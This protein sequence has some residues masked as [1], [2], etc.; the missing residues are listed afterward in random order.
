MRHGQCVPQ[1]ERRKTIASELDVAA[2]ETANLNNQ[3]N[4][5]EK[6]INSSSFIVGFYG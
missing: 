2:G 5:I 4:Q 6:S 1:V 3:E